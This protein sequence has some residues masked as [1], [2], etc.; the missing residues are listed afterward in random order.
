MSCS[1]SVCFILW[2]DKPS[3]IATTKEKKKR[4]LKRRKKKSEREKRIR[5]KE[6]QPISHEH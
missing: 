6:P 5:G 2:R 4:I 3:R 1:I